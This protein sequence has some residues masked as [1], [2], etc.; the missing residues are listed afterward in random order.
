MEKDAGYVF[1]ENN[2]KIEFQG[3]RADRI[4]DFA[5][6]FLQ[7]VMEKKGFPINTGI[8]FYIVGKFFL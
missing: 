2:N 8:L 1:D 7:Q 4:N 3:Y 6:E 5:L